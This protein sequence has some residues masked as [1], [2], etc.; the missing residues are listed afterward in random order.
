VADTAFVERSVGDLLAK[1]GAGLMTDE[2]AQR[3]LRAPW[4]RVARPDRSRWR[5]RRAALLALLIILDAAP[6]FALGDG[7][8]PGAGLPLCSSRGYEPAP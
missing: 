6:V 1:D 2:K 5:P 8:R 7:A 3:R 4:G